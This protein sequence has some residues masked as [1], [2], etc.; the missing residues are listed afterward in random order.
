MHFLLYNKVDQQMADRSLENQKQK[1]HFFSRNQNSIHILIHRS[2]VN[3]RQ[4]HTLKARAV[5]LI[6]P[7]EQK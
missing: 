1:R 7:E 3:A 4:S 6:A 5:V 2:I